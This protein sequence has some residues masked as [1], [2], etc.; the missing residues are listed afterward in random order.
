MMFYVKLSVNWK[1]NESALGVGTGRGLPMTG[2]AKRLTIGKSM[3]IDISS[4]KDLSSNAMK[5][6]LRMK[7]CLGPPRS[8]R[9]LL[10]KSFLE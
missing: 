5:N 10:R 1:G 6:I 3:G 4:G 7:R 9:Q 8:G 2:P